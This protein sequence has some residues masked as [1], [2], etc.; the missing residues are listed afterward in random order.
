[1][2]RLFGAGAMSPL[3]PVALG[4][5]L[6]W[7]IGRGPSLGILLQMN[8]LTLGKKI[9]IHDRDGSIT[10]RELDRLANQL[11][12]AYERAGIKGGDKIALLLRNGREMAAVALGAQKTG[13]VACPLNTWAKKKE[14]KAVTANVAPALLVYDTAHSDQV[15]SLETGEVQLVHVGNDDKALPGSLP[16]DDF[17]RGSSTRPPAP[18]TRDRGS[19]KIVIQTSGTTGTP[20]GAARDASAAGM[21]ALANL[22]GHVP[23]RRDDTVVCPAPLFHSF[24]LATFTFATAL[25]ATL[26]LPEKFDPEGTLALIDK[27]KATVASLVPVM[28]RRIVSLDDDVKEKYDLS[29]LRI[30][31]ASGSALSHDLKKEA[32]KLFGEVLYDLYGSTEIGW[33]AIARPQDIA[34]K[35]KSV[36]RPVDGIDVAVFAP[37]GKKLPAGEIGELYIKSDVLFEG[38]TSGETKDSRDGYM[39]IGDLGKLDEE[40]FLYIESRSDDMVI[41]GGENIYPI[42]VEEVIESI[43][44]V[45]EV[46]V[47][48]V[49][50]DEYGH[51]LVAF[52]VG[53]TTEEAVRSVC[54][55][56][57]ASFKVPRKVRIVDELPRTSTG[58]VLKRELIKQFEKDS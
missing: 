32:T 8:A 44:G 40:G 49:P 10:W 30:V 2:R 3:T 37:D 57:L 13:V 45:T 47:F 21:G 27:H 51:V 41:V 17:L 43:P 28:M 24:G 12:H 39:S 9:A 1:M 19:A 52:V 58:K 4:S 53:S 34:T 18:L 5:A 33:V 48:G 25:G 6:P 35:P 31:M 46:T 26:V 11:A 7:L 20:K 29:S 15:K 38:Y 22:L 54:S 14:L 50:D 56:E 23:Y 55:E 42:E 16:F 36:G